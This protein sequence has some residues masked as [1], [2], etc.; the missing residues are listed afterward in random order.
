MNDPLQALDEICEE[1]EQLNRQAK[2]HYWLHGWLFVHVP[3]SYAL[4]A[5]SAI[6]AVIALRY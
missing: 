1:R 4:L 6:H 3:L 2:L 5:L